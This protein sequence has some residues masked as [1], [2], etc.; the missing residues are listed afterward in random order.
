M[1]S[2]DYVRTLAFMLIILWVLIIRNNGYDSTT[3]LLILVFA[4]IIYAI[5]GYAISR[6]GKFAIFAYRQLREYLCSLLLSLSSFVLLF[7]SL[8]PFIVL[9][10][11]I[12]WGKNQMT[13]AMDNSITDLFFGSYFDEIVMDYKYNWIP[14]LAVIV[15]FV[16]PVVIWTISKIYGVDLEKLE[17]GIVSRV[18][19]TAAVVNASILSISLLFGDSP[20]DVR[21]F[22]FVISVSVPSVIGYIGFF[23][24]KCS[25]IFKHLDEEVL[26]KP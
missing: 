10:A 26:P 3:L 6:G 20:A 16:F 14:E 2:K 18:F 4:A 1:E 15:V 13:G 23:L 9:A 5:R 22:R 21:F 11:V 24:Y 25:G 19:F 8:L 12:I 17:E 7:M